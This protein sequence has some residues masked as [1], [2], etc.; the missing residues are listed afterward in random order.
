MQKT[1][2]QVTQNTLDRLKSLKKY[3]RQSY[4]DLLNSLAD[5]AEEESLSEEEITQIQQAL[6]DVKNG[7]VY[8]IQKVAMDLG[9]KLK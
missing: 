6:E 2:I 5:D 7:R 3:D 1:T 8:P 4:N 9:V